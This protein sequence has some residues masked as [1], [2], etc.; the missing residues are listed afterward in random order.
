MGGNI[1]DL[2]TYDRIQAAVNRKFGSDS[3]REA[4]CKLAGCSLEHEPMVI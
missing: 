1:P 2:Y 3:K 4:P